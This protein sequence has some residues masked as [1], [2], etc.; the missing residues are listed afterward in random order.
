M[1]WI[2]KLAVALCEH[3]GCT[4]YWDHVVDPMGVAAKNPKATRDSYKAFKMVGRKGDIE[5]VR[6][7]FDWL[8]PVIVDLMKRNASGLGM[9]Y[10]QNYACGVVDG[11]KNQLKV[12]HQ[13]AQREAA[14]TNQ[15]TAMVFLNNRLDLSKN[16][17]KN[18]GPKLIMKTSNLRNDNN[19]KALG[20]KA[21]ESIS[22]N[23]GINGASP[24]KHLK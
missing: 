17:L 16:H 4:G 9:S 12:E 5:I 11:I 10:S 8:Q 21:G 3:Y 2:G 18:H 13:R 22:L 24:N 15:S 14:A 23:K 20:V 1:L 19:A 6:Y 7:F